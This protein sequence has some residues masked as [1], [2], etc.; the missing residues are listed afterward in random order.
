M[1]ETIERIAPRAAPSLKKWFVE[2]GVPMNRAIG[3]RIDEVTHDSSRVVIRL[4]ARRRN[5][6]VGG[7]IHGGVITALAETVHGIAVLWQFPPSD[8]LMVSR[9][10]NVEFIHPARG[11]LRVEYS[12]A[13]SVRAQIDMELTQSGKCD[14]QLFS[15]VKDAKG[16]IVA[17]LEGTYAI[18]IRRRDVSTFPE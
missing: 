17:R 16:I 10:L 15:E 4:P 13:E 5:M 11:A 8:H 3:L 2:F 6:N 12:L 18:R 9:R 7:T 1:L 14:V